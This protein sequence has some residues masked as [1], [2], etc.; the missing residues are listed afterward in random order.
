M[1]N[2]VHGKTVQNVRRR[3]NVR[4]IDNAKYYIKYVR[5]PIFVLQKIFSKDLIAIHEIKPVLIL[6][7]PIYVGISI[8]DLSKLFMYDYHY[9]H[10]KR[11]LDAN[12]IFTYAGS[13]TYEIKTE[14]DIYEIFCK[15]ENLFD[16]SNY[17]KHSKF[18]DLFNINEI[19]KM[20][21]ESEAKIITEFVG[22]KSKMY[23][24]IN[25]DDKENKKG[26]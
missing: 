1:I 11:K 14:E 9:N 25:V 22:L 20:K 23:S 4:L 19:G 17:P 8:P 24:L 16:F 13:L 5:K 6:D 7:K 12:L 3:N 26:K 21:D 10:I 18:Y 2:S 15:D